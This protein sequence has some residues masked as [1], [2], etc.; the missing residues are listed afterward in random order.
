MICPLD[1]VSF[2]CLAAVSQMATA[3]CYKAAGIGSRIRVLMELLLPAQRRKSIK[4]DQ[5]KDTKTLLIKNR[6]RLALM[7]NLEM[8]RKFLLSIS[9]SLKLDNFFIYINKTR[10]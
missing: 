9:R 6:V 1:R 3:T 7:M 4:C 10:H 2:L 8:K 5:E